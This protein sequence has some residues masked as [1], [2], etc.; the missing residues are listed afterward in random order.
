M[1]PQPSLRKE[2]ERILEV[3]LVCRH[4]DPGPDDSLY[5]SLYDSCDGLPDDGSSPGDAVSPDDHILVIH[6]GR[7]PDSL[8]TACMK[9]VTAYL[10]EPQIAGRIRWDSICTAFMYF[11]LAN[12]DSVN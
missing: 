3:I 9:A 2:S 8:M 10:D 4:V 5:D 1:T 12:E 7:A 11:N 6:P